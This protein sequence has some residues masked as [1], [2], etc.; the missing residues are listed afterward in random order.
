M[1]YSDYSNNSLYLY[2]RP[3]ENIN[4]YMIEDLAIF[5]SGDDFINTKKYL[6]NLLDNDVQTFKNIYYKYVNIKNN[7]MQKPR[8]FINK[9]YSIDGAYGEDPHMYFGKS[10]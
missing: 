7:K 2:L 6:Y 1:S 5:I 4:D 10:L 3:V 8:Q 9:T